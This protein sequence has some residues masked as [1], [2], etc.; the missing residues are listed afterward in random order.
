MLLLV[1]LLYFYYCFTWY[2]RTYVLHDF[3]CRSTFTSWTKSYGLLY[4]CVECVMECYDA[5]DG[6]ETFIFSLFQNL[7]SYK[8]TNK[9]ERF[10]DSNSVLANAAIWWIRL[11]MCIVCIRAVMMLL[12]LLLIDLTECTINVVILR[13]NKNKNRHTHKHIPSIQLF[14]ILH[15]DL[16]RRTC[17]AIYLTS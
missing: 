4:V 16:C 17:Y 2:F 3:N 9:T 10:V 1:F 8:Q 7:D 6:V 15:I 13:R 11:L 12:F 14:C 5:R